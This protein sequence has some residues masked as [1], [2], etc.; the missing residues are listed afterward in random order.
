MCAIPNTSQFT[1][2]QI[3]YLK[4]KEEEEQ[5]SKIVREQLKTMRRHNR[6]VY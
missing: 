5:K 3:I 6:I 1:D 4:K 2:I